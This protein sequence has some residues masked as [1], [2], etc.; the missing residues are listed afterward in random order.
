MAINVSPAR[1]AAFE[2]LQK[3][4][5]ERAFSAILLP[6]YEENLKPE[7]RALCHALT[8]GILRNQ[9]LLDSL[10]EHFSGKKVGKLDLAVKIALRIGMFQ[11]RS[12]EKIPA[13][14]AV[15][16]SVNLV[17]LAKKRSAAGFVNAVLRKSERETN[18]DLLDKFTNPLEKLSIE[19]SHPVW[20]L[21]KW[22]R[23]FGFEE[24]EK[25]AKTN[26]QQPPTAFRLTNQDSETILQELETADAKLEKSKIANNAFR[27]SGA[28]QAVR[29]LVAENK[30]YLQDEASQ[31]VGET[32]NLN[33]EENFL[34][35]CAAPGSKT[36][37]IVRCSSFVVRSKE[38]QRTTNDEQRTNLFVAGDFTVPRVSILRETI[39]R[40]GSKEIEIVRYDA[41][42]LPFADESFDAVLV[43]AP[44]SGTGTI[45]HNP[46]I[47]YHLRET[48]FAELSKLQN[49][50]L[51]S[52]ARV[53]KKNGRLVYST[54]SLEPE[55]NEAVIDNFLA[56]N[57]NFKII[58]KKL[59]A[60]FLT[61]KGYG[62]TFP[63]R[64]DADGFFI[65]NLHRTN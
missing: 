7:D 65:A 55:E 15:N 2:I 23:Y 4:E 9:F 25:L 36:T 63:P 22:R 53:L 28:T 37:Q 17:Y 32:I 61:D 62:R 24:T 14:A 30:I 16:E 52:A 39:E 40:F 58:A 64:D 47:R 21:E 33:P 10:I 60:R 42:K 54:C 35:V 59:P 3:V 13:R 41:R 43:D 12:M 48:D 49:A 8:L 27:V 31:L 50:I 34:D 44:C 5:A 6:A 51:T 18:F 46:E 57:P 29:K 38:N 20:L 19:T 45:R 26:N 11:L 1:K 56:K